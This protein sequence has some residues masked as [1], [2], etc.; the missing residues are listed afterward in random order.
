MGVRPNRPSPDRQLARVF[1]R[2]A[3][4]FFRSGDATGALYPD[5][6][7]YDFA[8]A[9]ELS[10]KAFLLW[11]GL[12]DDWNRR[13]IR[14]DL[15]QA[16]RCA[17]RAGLDEIPAGLEA[18][19]QVLSPAYQRHAIQSQA[20]QLLA[21]INVPSACET[22]RQLLDLVAAVVVAEASSATDPH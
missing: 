19:V 1:L 8:I 18:L 20:G 17:R 5:H 14:H 6:A 15:R 3:G 11:R 7:L 2:N 22:V 21:L 4:G 12:T 13:H 16:L 10:L 9:I